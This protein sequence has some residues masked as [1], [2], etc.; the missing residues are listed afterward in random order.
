MLER[1]LLVAQIHV[2]NVANCLKGRRHDHVL[3]QDRL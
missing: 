2:R 3:W 1:E